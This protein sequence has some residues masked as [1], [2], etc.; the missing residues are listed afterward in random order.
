MYF[1]IKLVLL[2]QLIPDEMFSSPLCLSSRALLSV[3]FRKPRA[4]KKIGREIN[5]PLVEDK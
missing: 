1:K 3:Q 5:S 4:V 2:L